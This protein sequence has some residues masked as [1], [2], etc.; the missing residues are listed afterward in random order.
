MFGKV[1]R[2]AFRILSILLTLV[3]KR[4]VNTHITVASLLKT[5]FQRV[6]FYD[7]VKYSVDDKICTTD[8]EHISFFSCVKPWLPMSKVLP[9][10]T[11][12]LHSYSSFFPWWDPTARQSTATSHKNY[13]QV[14]GTI[15]KKHHFFMCHKCLFIQDISCYFICAYFLWNRIQVYFS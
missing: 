12:D 13:I 5:F 9:L 10:L 14:V 7:Q 6:I 11:K 15:Q 1:L 3:P 8:F 2:W 4:F